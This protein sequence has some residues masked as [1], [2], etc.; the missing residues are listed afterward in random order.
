MTFAVYLDTQSIPNRTNIS[1]NESGSELTAQIPCPLL[2]I[3]F[4][5]F[6]R[7][8][9]RPTELNK[10]LTTNLLISNQYRLVIQ[11]YTLY[12]PQRKKTYLLT[13]APNEDLNQPAHARSDQTLPCG[14]EETLC[15]WLSKMRPVKILI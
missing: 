5:F 4:V 2:D 8:Y 11:M 7:G 10:K 9:Y 6:F 13:C 12:E 3:Y 14:H 1:R 15:L